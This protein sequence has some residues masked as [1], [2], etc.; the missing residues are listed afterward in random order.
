MSLTLPQP[1]ASL[2][3]TSEFPLTFP[4]WAS[5]PRL[6]FPSATV[7]PKERRSDQT[8]YRSISLKEAWL[9]PGV[10]AGWHLG[11]VTEGKYSM[12]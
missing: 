8:G 1:H 6:H 3:L 11:K 9:W 7:F 12:L 5:T 10:P 2:A 4:S